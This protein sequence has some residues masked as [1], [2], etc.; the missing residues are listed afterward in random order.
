MLILFLFFRKLEHPRS[1]CAVLLSAAGRGRM[2]G[3]R[4]QEDF[5][6][7]RRFRLPYRM[8]SLSPPSP[9]PSSTLSRYPKTSLVPSYDF[10][11]SLPFSVWISHLY[12]VTTAAAVT[13][14]P[15][16]V[17]QAVSSALWLLVDFWPPSAVRLISV[18]YAY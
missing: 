7:R 1:N 15:H 14:P 17:P 3:A 6:V 5:M 4:S 11:T 12:K 10:Q 18:G 2:N 9:F 13:A 8:P 16:A